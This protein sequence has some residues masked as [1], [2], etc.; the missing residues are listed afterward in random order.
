MLLRNGIKA[1]N[2]QLSNVCTF[3]YS[4]LLHSYRRDGLHSGRALGIIAMKENP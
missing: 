2:I 1:P 4:N 3:E